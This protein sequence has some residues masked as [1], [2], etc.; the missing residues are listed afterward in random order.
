VA[1]VPA[2]LVGRDIIGKNYFQVVNLSK[3]LYQCGLNGLIS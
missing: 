3:A 1:V 2:I